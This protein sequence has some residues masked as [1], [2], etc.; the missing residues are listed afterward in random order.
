[1][2]TGPVVWLVSCACVLSL[3]LPNT[4]GFLGSLG[5]GVEG[6]CHTSRLFGSRSPLFWQGRTLRCIDRSLQ[7]TH[8]SLVLCIRACVCACAYAQ[9]CVVFDRSCCICTAFARFRF[10]SSTPYVCPPCAPSLTGSTDSLPCPRSCNI[11]SPSISRWWSRHVR[12]PA[13]AV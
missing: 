9:T 2:H 5:H 4:I 12:M 7:G 3:L 8:L 10:F 11:R 13:R 6:P 1:M